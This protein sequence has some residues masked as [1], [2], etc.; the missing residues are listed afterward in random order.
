[1]N[2][3]KPRLSLVSLL[4][5]LA[6]AADT[7]GLRPERTTA[8]GGAVYTVYPQDHYAIGFVTSRPSTSDPNVVFSVAAAFTGT[9]NRVVGIYV[10]D[11]TVGNRKSISKGIGGVVIIESGNAHLL[12][13][14]KAAVLTPDFT[15][16]VEKNKGSLFQQF[17][18]INDGKPT[19]FK[20]KGKSRR[21]ALVEF[22][23]GKW[24]VVETSKPITINAVNQELV[25]M[26]AKTALYLDMGGWDEGWY[27]DATT[28]KPITIGL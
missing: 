1:M 19:A 3:R 16:R 15:K 2:N 10:A 14:N 28:G 12:A 9:T 23:S 5:L 7:V 24:G 8:R 21:R 20:D 25:T 26:G 11:G 17:L 4:S 13:S 18:L 27:R 22:K 6:A